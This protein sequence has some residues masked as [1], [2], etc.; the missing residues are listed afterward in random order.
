MEDETGHKNIPL[1][2]AILPMIVLISLLA[3]SVLVFG[4]NALAGANQIS[5]MS[6]AAFAGCLAAMRGLAWEK[7]LDKIV[8]S[9]KVAIPAILILM[10][11]GSLSGAWIISGIVPTMIY[12]GIA[13][14][15]PA[16]FL[17]VAVFLSSLVS[18]VTGSSWSTIATIGVALMGIG[19]SL[20]LNPAIIAG[21]IISGSYFGDKLSPLSDTTNLAAAVAGTDLFT[22][23]K[24]MLYT[25]VPSILISLCLFGLLTVFSSN[26]GQPANAN[27]LVS[28]LESTFTISAWF[29]LVPVAVI[30][31]IIKR[32][33]ALP[34]LLAGTVLG[35]VCA[36]IFQRDLV[37]S[38]GGDVGGPIAQAFGGVMRILFDS[39]Q[40]ETGN[41]VVDELLVTKGMSGMMGTVWLI[42]SAM[43]FGGAMDAGGFLARITS[44]IMS[45]AKSAGALVVATVGSSMFT[46]VTASD[47]YLSVV[48]PGR[49]FA[50]AF[51][52]AGLAPENLSRSIEDGGTVTSVLVPWN[53]CGAYVS[54]VLGIST[55]SYAPFAFF[56]IISP[57]MSIAYAVFQIRIK[58]REMN[59]A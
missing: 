46:N 25:T 13:F 14:I 3:S 42:I 56:C 54:G 7:I 17:I 33:P 22:H 27:E 1:I 47:Q 23:V 29:M 16:V 38:I 53:T 26:S 28:A 55:F 9:I 39:V 43:T 35:L 51:E 5:L 44:A 37:M 36:L 32:V 24:Y 12:Y 8:H 4:D 59:L 15:H 48:V 6:A 41:S 58:R 45:R 18:L 49:M 11:V 31:L 50:P 30:V 34:A 20:G 52:K 2:V 21:A 19:A 57:F 40:V 10:L